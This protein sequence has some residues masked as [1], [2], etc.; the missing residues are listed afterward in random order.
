MNAPGDVTIERDADATFTSRQMVLLKIEAKD[1]PV[2]FVMDHPRYHHRGETEGE[3]ERQASTAYFFEEHSCPTNWL[4]ECV[5][6]IDGGDC[7]PHGF[8]EFVRAADVPDDFDADNDANWITL[9]PEAFP[10]DKVI[11]GNLT[12]AGLPKPANT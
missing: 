12:P 10:A 4:S 3:D 2:F 1:G 11:D 6:V 9:F 7:D 5:A 8:L